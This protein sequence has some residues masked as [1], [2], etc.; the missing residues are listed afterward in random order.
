M[1]KKRKSRLQKIETQRA[2]RSAFVYFILTII[3]IVLIFMYGF[4]FLS[5]ITGAVYNYFKNELPITSDTLAPAPPRLFIENN[6]TS[7]EEIKLEGTAEAGSTAVL[8]INGSEYDAVA[9]AGGEFSLSVNLKEG[10]NKIYATATDS[11]GNTSQESQMY[12]IIYD[13]KPP[14]INISQPAEGQEFTGAEKQIEIKGSL[15]EKGSLTLN[16][17][18]VYVSSDGSFETNY[19][20]ADGE[21]KLIFEALDLADNKSQINLT[22]IYR[23]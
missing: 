22:V 23:P 6:Y 10:T 11:A 2:R 9:D 7:S 21:N 16:N 4:G 19:E 18:S 1:T 13:T 5:T 14:V 12:E 3:L 15:G 17:K 20:L 8:H